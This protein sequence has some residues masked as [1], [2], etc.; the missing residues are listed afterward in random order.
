M[1]SSISWGSYIGSIAIMILL[2]Y[3]AII[4]LYYRNDIGA[5]LLGGNRNHEP[6][7]VT[8]QLQQQSIQPDIERYQ[9]QAVQSVGLPFLAQ[10]VADEVNAY[11]MEAK[12]EELE[13]LAVLGGLRT[14]LSKYPT[15]KGTHYQQQTEDFIIEETKS[16]CNIHLEDEAGK[17]W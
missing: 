3:S 4:Y 14:I 15:I 13:R 7:Q 6:T 8:S 10:A 2:Y 17:L 1:L 12:T 16:I 5:I 9:P 11:L